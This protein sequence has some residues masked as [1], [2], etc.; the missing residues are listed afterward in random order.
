[1]SHRG[2]GVVEVMVSMA[3]LAVGI[4]VSVPLLA[5]GLNQGAEGRKVTAAQHLGNQ[6]LERLRTEIRYDA[7]PTG[8]SLTGGPGFSLADAWKSDRLPYSSEDVV[9]TGATGKLTTCNPAG[10]DDKI[11]YKVGPFAMAFEG[12][13]YHV[14]YHLVPSTRTD[15]PAESV[16]ATIKVIWTSATGGYAAR[17]IS[18]LLLNG[19]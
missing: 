10:V 14:C 13:Q 16:E 18:G 4:A 5:V 12:N 9:N 1:M 11:P 2:F 8:G 19:R 15:V 3:V 17:W 6:V 7:Q